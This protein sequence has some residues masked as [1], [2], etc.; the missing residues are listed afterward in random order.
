MEFTSSTTNTTTA[1]ASG[2]LSEGPADPFNWQNPV[3]R[4]PSPRGH[5]SGSTRVPGTVISHRP[6]WTPE[7]HARIL[8]QIKATRTDIDPSFPRETPVPA[9]APQTSAHSMVKDAIQGVTQATQSYVNSF[10]EYAFHLL[11]QAGEHVSARQST[12][13]PGNHIDWH[14]PPAR[15]KEVFFDLM[16]KA[17]TPKELAIDTQLAWTAAGIPFIDQTWPTYNKPSLRFPTADIRESG[18]SNALVAEFTSPEGGQYIYKCFPPAAEVDLNRLS[19]LTGMDPHMPRREM[20]CLLTSHIAHGLLQWDVTPKL[21][22]AMAGGQPCLVAPLVKGTSLKKRL[23]N[24][25][26]LGKLWQESMSDGVIRME[27]WTGRVT[28]RFRNDYIRILLL[29]MVVGDYDRH[30]GQYIVRGKQPDV[31]QAIDW[32]TAFGSKILDDAIFMNPKTGAIVALWPDA[33]PKAICDEF[34]QLRKDQLIEAAEAFG[35]T[36]EEVKALISRF[37]VITKKLATI[38]KI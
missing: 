10:T 25:L 7:K 18:A 32:D 29:S 14:W 9:D 1:G 23:M 27:M 19:D 8:A 12:A 30:V 34:A 13:Q 31:I 16:I 22:L 17:G 15:Q 6:R 4:M 21:T 33:I 2:L 37:E 24:S 35:M 38:K 28:E 3:F 36:G 11:Y 5:T 26:S 20:R